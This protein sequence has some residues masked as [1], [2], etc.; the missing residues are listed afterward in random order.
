[1]IYIDSPVVVV[2]NE[3]LGGAQSAGTTL[4]SITDYPNVHESVSS[5]V[6]NEKNKPEEN[7]THSA[8]KAII[9][10][11]ITYCLSQDIQNP[12]EMLRYLQ[13][14][15]VTGRKLEIEDTTQCVE[16]ETNFIL[17]NRNDLIESAFDEIDSISDI[18]KTL[19]QFYDEVIKM[20]NVKVV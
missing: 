3:D 4:S 7:E 8:I 1:M 15:V 19:V 18:R 12:V 16:G 14:V 13:S 11:A 17:V 20:Q 5:D 6:T 9:E 10:S 2:S